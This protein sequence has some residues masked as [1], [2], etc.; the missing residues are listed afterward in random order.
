M[1]IDQWFTSRI[2]DAGAI[3]I[4]WNGTW[5]HE[6]EITGAKQR[7]WKFKMPYTPETLHV[8]SSGRIKR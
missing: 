5:K 3:L 6:D 8:S 2:N 1:I 4:N 7:P